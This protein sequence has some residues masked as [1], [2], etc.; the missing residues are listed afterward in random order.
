M[1]SGAWLGQFTDILLK[2]NIPFTVMPFEGK[3]ACTVEITEG[4]V[5]MAAIHQTN[6]S[7]IDSCQHYQCYSILCLGSTWFWR[8]LYISHVRLIDGSWR[9]K[10]DIPLFSQAR[11]FIFVSEALKRSMARIFSF[12]S[13]KSVLCRTQCGRPY[14]VFMKQ[15]I[16]K[17]HPTILV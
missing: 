12:L 5:S 15:P 9:D 7:G 2:R 17:V 8:I 3:L 4:G 10:M 16:P 6:S 11:A 1:R 13:T 14:N